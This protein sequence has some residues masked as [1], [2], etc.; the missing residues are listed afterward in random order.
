MVCLGEM[1]VDGFLG[2][3]LLVFRLGRFFVDGV[4]FVL[5]KG[6]FIIHQSFKKL[7]KAFFLRKLILLGIVCKFNINELFDD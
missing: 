6:N 4:V 7:L 2:V 5:L 1:N 3:G